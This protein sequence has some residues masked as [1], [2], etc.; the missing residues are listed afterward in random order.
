MRKTGEKKKEPPPFFDE[1]HG[2]LGSKHKVNPTNFQDSAESECDVDSP[3]PS[4]S[5]MNTDSSDSEQMSTKVTTIQ[6][7]FSKVKTIRPKSA[8]TLLLEVLQKQ[9]EENVNTRKEEFKTLEKLIDKQNEQRKEEFKTL[10][11]LIDKQNEQRDRMLDLL[12]IADR[13]LDLVKNAKEEMPIPTLTIKS[14]L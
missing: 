4:T 1:M 13:M 11:K 14:T 3:T 7:R 9:H 12:T 8:N 6:N 5:G 10:E 2:I